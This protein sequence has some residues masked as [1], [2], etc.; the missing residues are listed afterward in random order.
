[1]CFSNARNVSAE[2]I[3]IK[4]LDFVALLRTPCAKRR[5]HRDIHVTVFLNWPEVLPSNF[6]DAV[7]RATASEDVFCGGRCGYSRKTEEK[8]ARCTTKEA[9]ACF[10]NARYGSIQFLDFVAFLRTPCAIRRKHC[11]YWADYCTASLLKYS[12]Q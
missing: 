3:N 6:T 5:K 1:M 12:A 4:F 8:G 10:P 2:Y 11:F 7:L 9:I